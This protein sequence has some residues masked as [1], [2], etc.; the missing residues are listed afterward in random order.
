MYKLVHLAFSSCLYLIQ[1]L[2]K[3][4]AF[5]KVSYSNAQS[6]ELITAGAK[7]Q[8]K[9]KKT[10]ENNFCGFFVYILEIISGSFL[11]DMVNFSMLTTKHYSIGLE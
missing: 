3:T 6:S 11:M 1:K 5:L 7:L 8:L 4:K 2:K 10:Q 9:K